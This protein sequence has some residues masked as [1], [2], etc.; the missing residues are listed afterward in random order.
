MQNALQVPNEHT[1]PPDAYHRPLVPEPRDQGDPFVLKLT[2]SADAAF[3]YYAYTTS[4]GASEAGRVFMAY[5]SNDLVS[6]KPLGFTLEAEAGR[7]HWAP[8]VELVP[9]LARPYVM[10]YSRAVGVGEQAHVG[11][12]IYRADAERP[13]GPFVPSG[14]VLTP[15]EIDFAIDPDLSRS[16]DGTRI[17]RFAL[18]FIEGARIGTGLGEI[19]VS[20][21]LARPLGPVRALSRA[22]SDWQLFHPARVM[23][24]KS[25]PGVSWERGDTVAWHCMEAPATLVSPSGKRTVLYSGGCYEKLYAVGVLAEQ[26]NGTYIDL[27]ATEA[28]CLVAPDPER[29]IFAP[30]HCSVVK[31]PEGLDY[32]VFHARYGSLSAE[33]QMSIAPIAWRGDAPYCPK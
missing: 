4:S 25:I 18:D 5:G 29:G 20:E 12:R 8:C 11:H 10:L 22:Q 15:G 28:E 19:P 33:R 9:G 21:D 32:M 17:L 27:S 26:D 1:L 24:W 16:T 14:H 23:P 30:G 31:G 2:G 13:E 7:E 3:G 6:W